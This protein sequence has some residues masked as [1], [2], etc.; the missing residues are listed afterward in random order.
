MVGISLDKQVDAIIN[1][2][3]F[4]SFIL[5]LVR[6]FKVNYVF[7]V[8]CVVRYWVNWGFEENKQIGNF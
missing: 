1:P 3:N 5:Y 4:F 8:I 6:L 7:N 2:D